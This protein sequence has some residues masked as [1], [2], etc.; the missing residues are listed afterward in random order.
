LP[1]ESIARWYG[2]GGHWID[3]G[4]THYVSIDREPENGFEV[5]SAA[6]GRSGIMLN[7]HLV[8]TGEHEAR[9]LRRLATLSLD[10]EEH[11]YLDSF[12]PGQGREE[13]YALTHI[14]PASRHLRSWGVWAS[15][16]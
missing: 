13:P 8:K 6:C 1:D 15:I 9:G 12:S 4:F 14:L 2:Q 16:S 10:M 3:L 5:Q 11:F 7:I